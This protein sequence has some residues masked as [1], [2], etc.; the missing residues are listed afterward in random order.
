MS[1][2]RSRIAPLVGAVLVAVA[3]VAIGVAQART[4]APD[5][6]PGQAL[7]RYDHVVVVIFENKNYDQMVGS[8]YA[9]Y[10]N[11]LAGEGALLTQSYGVTHPSQGNYLALYSG[12]TQ[13]VNGDNCP[14]TYRADHLGNQLIDAGFTFMAYSENL[15]QVGFTGCQSINGLYVRKHAP[16]VNFVGFDQSLHV[17]F[18]QFPAGYS[19]LP[20]VSF[21]IPNICDDMHNCDIQVGDT[22]LRQHLDGYVQWAKTHNSLL[23]TTFDEDDFTSANQIYTSFVGEGVPQQKYDKQVNHYSVLRTLEDMY[24]LPPLGFAADSEAVDVFGP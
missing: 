8:P 22:W 14:N 4:A 18:S 13:N 17:P 1:R 6:V 15:P 3:A 23:I 10:F 20:T 12:S 5:P 21:V 11:Q 16:W 24:G 19:Q 2:Q 7:P 9:P